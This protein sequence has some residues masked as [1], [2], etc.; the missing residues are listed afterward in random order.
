MKRS[1]QGIA[2]GKSRGEEHPTDKRRAQT[3]HET[4]PG[5]S[6][7]REQA[8]DPNLNDAEKGAG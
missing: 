7:S 1:D 3:A 2:R 6:V 4:K 5:K 8:R